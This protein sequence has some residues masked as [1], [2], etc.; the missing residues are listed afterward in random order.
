[1]RFQG[2]LRELRD[3]QT[4]G[5]TIRFRVSD[6]PKAVEILSAHGAAARAANDELT[7]AFSA[8]EAVARMNRALS[9]AGIDVYEINVVRSDLESVFMEL[10]GTSGRA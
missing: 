3:R 7:V 2:T 5:S 8:P 10:I 4:G 9:E 1:M 6:A